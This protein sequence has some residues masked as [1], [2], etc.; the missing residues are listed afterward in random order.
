MNF[1]EN[2]SITAL[3]TSKRDKHNFGEQILTLIRISRTDLEDKFILFWTQTEIKQYTFIL[4]TVVPIDTSIRSPSVE[5]WT[6][7]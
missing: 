1:I 7:K 2:F 3:T 6:E 4:T 5:A